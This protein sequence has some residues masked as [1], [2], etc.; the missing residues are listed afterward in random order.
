MSLSCLSIF[1]LI[2]FLPKIYN[3]W[4]ATFFNRELD[5][6]QA[7]NMRLSSPSE[8]SVITKPQ[9]MVKKKVTILPFSTV[10]LVC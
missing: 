9:R 7:V 5:K 8:A 4:F 2:H 6:R 10:N 3:H 1:I